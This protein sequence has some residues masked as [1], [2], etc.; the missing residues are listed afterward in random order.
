MQR[1]NLQIRSESWQEIDGFKQSLGADFRTERSIR[2]IPSARLP[3]V[4]WG[5]AAELRW[6]ISRPEEIGHLRAQGAGNPCTAIGTL[7]DWEGLPHPRAGR[8]LSRFHTPSSL[9]LLA[10]PVHRPIYGCIRQRRKSR[11]YESPCRD[12]FPDSSPAQGDLVQNAV[13]AHPADCEDLSV[14]VLR[15]GHSR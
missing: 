14:M 9:R 1:Q 7:C 6:A 5:L 4:L 11:Q 3:T 13:P 2:T 12:E 10:V 8:R 15:K